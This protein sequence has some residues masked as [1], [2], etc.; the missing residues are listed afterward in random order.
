MSKP[1][2]WETKMEAALARARVEGKPVLVDF[3]NPG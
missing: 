2:P 3:F 1:I